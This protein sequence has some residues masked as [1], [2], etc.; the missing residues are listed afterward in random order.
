MKR[1]KRLLTPYEAI[2]R[3]ILGL[4]A[5]RNEAEVF[6][7]AR[8]ADVFEIRGSGISDDIFSFALSAHF[9]FVV[10]D[11]TFSPLFAVEFDE[12][13]HAT[14]PKSRAD[15]KKKNLICEHFEL[16]LA[17]VRDEHIFQSARGINYVT[18]LTELFFATQAIKGA[19][20]SGIIPQD[21]YV[22]ALSFATLPHLPGEFPLFL[23][24]VA[25]I[26]LMSFCERGI[27]AD[28]VPLH[29]R[30]YTPAGAGES[31]VVVPTP[32]GDLLFA[33]ATI[34]L[35][36][37]GIPPSEAAEELAIVSLSRLVDE[38]SRTAKGAFEAHVV[39]DLIIRFLR[40][41]KHHSFGG[42]VGT[43]LGFSLRYSGSHWEV[44]AL[45]DEP[46]VTIAAR[47]D[48]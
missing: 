15:D 38:Y 4:A 19:Y 2:T 5:D 3:K 27:L 44:G 18:W 16:P 40:N 22:D 17:R 8:I 9:D 33:S 28:S 45:A 24:S 23:S 47:E 26:R 11:K 14:D 21:D 36:G 12:R 29:L 48:S 30:G 20:E 10:T 13:H 6:A 7:I 32:L 35:R 31:L 39:R 25:R 46:P 37:F 41:T 34:Y 43:E 1:V 42:S